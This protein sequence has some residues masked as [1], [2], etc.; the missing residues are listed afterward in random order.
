MHPPRLSTDIKSIPGHDLVM[1][2]F[3]VC[4][5]CARSPTPALCDVTRS[6]GVN[7]LVEQSITAS[8]ELCVCDGTPPLCTTVCKR[9]ARA[10]SVDLA[11]TCSKTSIAAT[12]G[13]PTARHAI[14]PRSI[15]VV[16]GFPQ[17]LIA[18]VT[19]RQRTGLMSASA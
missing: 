14:N 2:R 17:L 10:T 5:F 16:M 13:Q 6:D 9:F 18:T 4:P 1:S 15:V 3:T 8:K 7:I 12:N 11:N 19:H